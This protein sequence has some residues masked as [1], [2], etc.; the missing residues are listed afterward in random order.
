MSCFALHSEKLLGNSCQRLGSSIASL[1]GKPCLG[2]DKSIPPIWRHPSADICKIVA[3]VPLNA[4]CSLQNVIEH[5]RHSIWTLE[6]LRSVQCS[7]T[8][9][10]IMP[11]QV[12]TPHEEV[13]CTASIAHH[14]WAS[15][16]M[17]RV[18]THNRPPERC[19]HDDSFGACAREAL[20]QQGRLASLLS[21][22]CNKRKHLNI[23]PVTRASRAAYTIWAGLSFWCCQSD[24]VTCRHQAIFSKGMHYAQHLYDQNVEP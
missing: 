24:M 4:S 15:F 8:V 2:P 23:C 11:A 16:L 14:F 6:L 22:A 18:L 17:A 12:C 10:M 20:A 19:H 3:W 1:P 21:P 13:S 7:I 9:I 5:L